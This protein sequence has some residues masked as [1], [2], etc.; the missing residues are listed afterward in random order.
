MIE[1][2]L[3]TRRAEVIPPGWKSAGQWVD[4][5]GRNRCVVDQ[6]IRRAAAS[7][8]MERKQFKVETGQGVRKV[9][10]YKVVEKKK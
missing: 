8:L 9:W 3:A 4:E 10:H 2:E 1:A 7:G 6:I 5:T